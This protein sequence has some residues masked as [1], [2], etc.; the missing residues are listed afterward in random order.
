[1]I[2]A[3][4]PNS[5]PR[6]ISSR[7]PSSWTAGRL[8]I[9]FLNLLASIQFVWFYVNRVPSCMRLL[10][11]EQGRERTPFQYRLLLMLPLRWA[12]A[13]PWLNSIAASLTAQRGWFHAGVRPE[14]ILEAAIDLTCIAVAGLA[15]RKLYRASSRTGLLTPLIYP[16]VLVMANGAYSLLTMHLLRFVYDLPSLAFFSVGLCLIY[17]RTHPL[18]F[19][20]LFAVATLNRETTL[21]LLLCFAIAQC[22]RGPAWDW[23]QIYSPG[24]LAVLLP[25]SGYWIG[26]HLWVVRHFAANPVVPFPGV[27]LNI[28]LLLLPIAWPQMIGA[29]AYLWPVVFAGRR[30]ILDP[31]LRAWLWVV[32]V[33]IAFMFRFGI[34]L[35]IR[36][37]A[38]LIPYIAVLAV[39]VFE[40]NLLKKLES[41]TPAPAAEWAEAGG[42]A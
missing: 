2:S 7:R 5:Y 9:G 3:S 21:L 10:P 26:W 36:I 34:I 42:S 17:F 41:K 15:A 25:L 20:A 22:K 14:G 37:F 19:M 13:S 28:G 4:Y 38:E 24:S 39:L 35:E 1:M 30:R 6:R 12:H 11:Y 23:Q 16:L 40:E 33:W 27:W 29:F 8:G 31:V 32:P 18:W